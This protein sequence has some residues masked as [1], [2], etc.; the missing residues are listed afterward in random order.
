MTALQSITGG[1]GSSHSF[2]MMSFRTLR[3]PGSRSAQALPSST[4][5]RY[6]YYHVNMAKPQP[7][8]HNAILGLRPF[9]DRGN[10]VLVYAQQQVNAGVGPFRPGLNVYI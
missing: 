9:V 1:V 7:G 10:P 6:G 2:Q 3:F 4:D 8:T 5:Q